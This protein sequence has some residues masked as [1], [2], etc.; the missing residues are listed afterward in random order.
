MEIWP[1]TL[2]AREVELLTNTGLAHSET[3]NGFASYKLK[4]NK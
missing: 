3:I 2:G 1:V 4:L